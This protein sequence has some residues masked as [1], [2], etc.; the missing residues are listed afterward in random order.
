MTSV[1]NTDSIETQSVDVRTRAFSTALDT[2]IPL[3]QDE[4]WVEDR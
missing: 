2:T 3:V 4:E 1:T